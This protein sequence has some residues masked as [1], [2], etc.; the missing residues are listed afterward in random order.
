M[1]KF[2]L[3]KEMRNTLHCWEVHCL[4]VVE[5]EAVY[6][7]T[8]LLETHTDRVCNMWLH[9]DSLRSDLIAAREEVFS[10]DISLKFA[11]DRKSYHKAKL[12][13]MIPPLW[14][15]KQGLCPPDFNYLMDYMTK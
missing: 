15:Q 5:D 12:M 8:K 6:H 13:A 9:L 1:S 14:Y 3:D 4:Q 7:K 11:K 10:K 2:D